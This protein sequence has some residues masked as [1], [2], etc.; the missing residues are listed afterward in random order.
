MP[1]SFFE[2]LIYPL[3]FQ[4]IS[5]IPDT[6]SHHFQHHSATQAETILEQ[7]ALGH[8]LIFPDAISILGKQFLLNIR[9]GCQKLFLIPADQLK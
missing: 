2:S 8:N 9:H 3:N 7:Q 1:I 6:T 4:S 5:V